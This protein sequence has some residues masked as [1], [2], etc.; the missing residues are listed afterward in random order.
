MTIKIEKPAEL[1][2]KTPGFKE[3]ER[4]ILERKLKRELTK[5]EG[6]ILGEGGVPYEY[7]EGPKEVRS[8]IAPDLSETYK[9]LE[10]NKIQE[11]YSPSNLYRIYR[12]T[13]NNSR[14]RKDGFFFGWLLFLILYVQFK[15]EIGKDILL[16]D[17]LLFLTEEFKKKRGKRAFKYNW[18]ASNYLMFLI[19]NKKTIKYP[20]TQYSPKERNGIYKTGTKYIQIV[21]EAYK[22]KIRLD[23]YLER[24]KKV[25]EACNR[26]T[27]H[28]I[29]FR[30][31]YG[32]DRNLSKRIHSFIM[33]EKKVSQH[34]LVKRYSNKRLEDIYSCLWFLERIKEV[35]CDM[36]N[37]EFY[38]IGKGK[39]LEEALPADVS[40][41]IFPEKC[42]KLLKD[43]LAD[44]ILIK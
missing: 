11:D 42:K 1:S 6:R 10:D 3:L 15:K 44:T 35:F 31:R 26:N 28:M 22:V 8:K 39:A 19:T 18:E 9:D 20:F 4:L 30:L 25:E 29:K 40:S 13:H 2:E 14:I 37:N 32:Y 33:Q 41:F 27:R 36:N 24:I 38:Y 23:V 16:L 21:V 34:K 5:E 7:K 43:T 17:L 12:L